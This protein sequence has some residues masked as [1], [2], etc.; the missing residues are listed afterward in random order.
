MA[1]MKI[2]NQARLCIRC[3]MLLYYVGCKGIKQGTFKYIVT[4]IDTL[5]FEAKQTKP[6]AGAGI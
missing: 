1:S 2:L 6:T 4:T 5:G 3:L